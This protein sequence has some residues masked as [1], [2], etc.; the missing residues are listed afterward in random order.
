MLTFPVVLISCLGEVDKEP[1]LKFQE[2]SGVGFPENVQL[3]VAVF[4]YSTSCLRSGERVT[5]GATTK[6]NKI[7]I[8]LQVLK[9]IQ[10]VP[11]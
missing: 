5:L 3:N 6:L 11:V 9:E 1:F 10:T 4:W 8:L 7:N 2:M